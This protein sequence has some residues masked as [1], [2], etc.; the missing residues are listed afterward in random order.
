MAHL[1][2]YLFKEIS[3]LVPIDIQW[4]AKLPRCWWPGEQTK[5]KIFFFCCLWG[6]QKF[7]QEHHSSD[8]SH[9]TD[10]T[11]SLTNCTTREL[12]ELF[13]YGQY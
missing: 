11:G 3:L 9:S 1:F 4:I 10:N 8:L 6:M 5:A 7:G 12:Q 2:I 13:L